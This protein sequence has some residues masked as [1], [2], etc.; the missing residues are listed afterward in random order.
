ME[1][2]HTSGPGE[3]F[4]NVE[5]RQL[6]TRI[7]LALRRWEEAHGWLCPIYTYRRTATYL[8]TEVFPQA[9]LSTSAHEKEQA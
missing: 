8:S 5:R 2:E 7:L 1:A 4:E 6:L 3:K 9:A